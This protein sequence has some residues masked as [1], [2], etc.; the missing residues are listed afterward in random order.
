MRNKR[1][2]SSMHRTKAG[3]FEKLQFLDGSSMETEEENVL[4]TEESNRDK[5][6]V[7]PE[8]QVITDTQ[9]YYEVSIGIL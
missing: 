7:V 5:Q 3:V 6:E 9:E 8:Q 4:T 2:G 1:L